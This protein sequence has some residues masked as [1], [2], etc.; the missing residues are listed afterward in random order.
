MERGII[1]LIPKSGKNLESIGDWRPI[2]LLSQVYKLFSGIIACRIKKLL[3]KLIS[4]CQKAYQKDKNIGKILLDILETISILN[5]HKK[6]AIILLIDFSKAFDSI[7]HKCIFEALNF[8][9]FGDHFVNIVKTMLSNRT[10]TVMIDGHQT[11]SFR[12]LRGVPQG[13]TASPYI[14]II[15]LELLLL[16]IK[17]NTKITIVQLNIVGCKPEDGGNLEIPQ[18]QCFA[19]DMTVIVEETENNLVI[20]KDLFKDFSEVSGLEINEGKTMVIRIGKNLNS[21]KPLTNKVNFKYTKNFRLLG[22]KIDNELKNMDKN[23]MDRHEKI[24]KAINL[25]K[26]FGLTTLGNLIISKTFLIS[27]LGYFL[28]V[29]KCPEELQKQIQL[30]IDNFVLKGPS[31]ISETRRYLKPSEGGIGMIDLKAYGE[32]LRL[33][34]IKRTGKGLW[35]HILK[36]KAGENELIHHLNPNTLGAMHDPIKPIINACKIFLDKYKEISDENWACTPL[37]LLETEQ[38][39]AGKGKKLVAPTISTHPALFQ[40]NGLCT[41]TFRD[42]V[43]LDSQTGRN[44]KPI[45]AS[46]EKIKT[47]LKNYDLTTNYLKLPQ[48]K[49]TL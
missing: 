49:K 19:D 32:S 30:D 34:W 25:W 36:Q 38:Q 37:N 2:T 6:P 48:I 27:Q 23:F 41:M 5:H 18:L 16:N 43:D 1:K 21:L 10:C 14:F 31:W 7:S 26:R 8:F 28:S 22:L 11:E 39:R 33:A 44:Q 35:S 13:D 46:D 3:P 12:I 24:K 40:R 17:C 47:N 29:L 4:N 45:L 15:V 20:L 9:N 42:L